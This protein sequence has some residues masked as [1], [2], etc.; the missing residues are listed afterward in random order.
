V[1]EV[2]GVI[3]DQGLGDAL[4]L[5]LTKHRI[6]LSEMGPSF[7]I[8]PNYVNP[9]YGGNIPGH[10]AQQALK[11]MDANF[12][13]GT[14]YGDAFVVGPPTPRSQAIE[15]YDEFI[16]S[17]SPIHLDRT[18]PDPFDVEAVRF[19]IGHEIG[20]G[21]DIVHNLNV[22]VMIT[23]YLPI[24]TSI[25]SPPWNA[26]PHNYDAADLAQIRLK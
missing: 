11:V 23:Q 18:T 25:S 6:F 20:H 22:T 1:S 14:K 5:P 16:M 21:I 19:I 24:T 12:G 26:I 9:G 3:G 7:T 13:P 10:F 4:N 15:V 2:G 17:A 8:T